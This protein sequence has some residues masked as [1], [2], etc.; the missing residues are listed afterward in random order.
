MQFHIGSMGS[1]S[2]ISLGGVFAGGG[3]VTGVLLLL[4][5]T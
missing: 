2:G 3:A 1:D 5:A 4:E